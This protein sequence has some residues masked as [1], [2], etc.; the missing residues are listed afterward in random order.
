MAACVFSLGV[1]KGGGKEPELSARKTL[2]FP[3]HLVQARVINLCYSSHH[4][5]M[6]FVIAHFPVIPRCNCPYISS[7]ILIGVAFIGRLRTLFIAVFKFSIMSFLTAA[8]QSVGMKFRH[9]RYISAGSEVLKC[10][11]LG[12]SSVIEIS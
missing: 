4:M 6:K 10:L 12:Y 1:G 3:H 9:V 11:M 2:K 5:C 8:L 7:H